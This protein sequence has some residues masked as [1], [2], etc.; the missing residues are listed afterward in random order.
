MSKFKGPILRNQP[1]V[2]HDCHW[3]HSVDA[4]HNICLC[5]VHEFRDGKEWRYKHGD[6]CPVCESRRKESK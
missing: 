1:A 5:G 2:R 6:E 3:F 4:Q